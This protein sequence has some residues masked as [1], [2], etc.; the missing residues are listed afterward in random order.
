MGRVGTGTFTKP[1]PIRKQTGID[2]TRTSDDRVF[3][4][5]KDIL[6]EM[7]IMNVHLSK[8]T[9]DNIIENDLPKGVI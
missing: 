1:L 9:D 7:K 3:E 4:T 6:V 8:I 5:L 2:E